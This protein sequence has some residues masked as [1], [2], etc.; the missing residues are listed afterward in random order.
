MVAT[1]VIVKDWHDKPPCIQTAG[2]SGSQEVSRAAR[3]PFKVGYIMSRFPKITE[4]FILFE[5][6]A[7]ERQG[8]HVEVY[9]L[10]HEHTEVI[11]PEARDFVEKAHFIPFFN[12]AILIAHWHYMR[13]K[14]GVYFKT[15][16][17]L[18]RE[19]WGSRRFFFG[20]IGLFPKAVYFS[21][22]MEAAGI[23]HVHAHFASHPA[24][25]AYTIHKLTGIPYSFTAHG[26]DLHRDQHMLREKV[27][28]ASFVVPISE[29]NREMILAE[30]QG[31]FGDKV[32]VIHCG[33]DTQ[34]FQPIDQSPTANQENRRFTIVCIGTLHEVKGQTFL[35]EACRLL[36]D[37]GI[38]FVCHFV[39]DGPDETML[40]KQAEEAG[41]GESVRFHGRLTREEVSALLQQ[42]DV[43]ATPSVPTSNGRREG[44]PVVLMEAMSSGVPA[45]ASRISGIPELVVD[46]ETGLLVPAGDPLALA[47][48]LERL[49]GDR[50]LRYRLS[51]NGRLKVINEFDLYEN[52]AV[53][54]RRFHT[55]V[56]V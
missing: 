55:E 11:H 17:T 29:Y 12:R 26:S 39:G 36:E 25:A 38:D 8:I 18:L 43:L 47:K 15:L 3:K 10:L 37:R 41:L 19:N 40:V 46:G 23:Q 34:V 24:A 35:I 16:A 9:P 48:A 51:R 32:I 6:L 42:A 14:P 52:A 2:L 7:V 49:Y 27:A 28:E 53:L 54:A 45:V 31:Q 44:I 20:A 33:V 56:S 13:Y 21:K 22:V 1:F 50:Q 30:C 5:M 4:T